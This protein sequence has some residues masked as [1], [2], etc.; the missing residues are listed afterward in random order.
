MLL[1]MVFL[2]SAFIILMV[3]IAPVLEKYTGEAVFGWL[4]GDKNK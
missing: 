2:A 3:F 4:R 1:N